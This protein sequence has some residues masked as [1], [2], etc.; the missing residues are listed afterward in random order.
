MSINVCRN[1]IVAVLESVAN[2][3]FSPAV[4]PAAVNMPYISTQVKSC[5]DQEQSKT[6][7]VPSGSLWLSPVKSERADIFCKE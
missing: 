4:I 7:W 3:M 6:L 5:V 1:Y 2:I